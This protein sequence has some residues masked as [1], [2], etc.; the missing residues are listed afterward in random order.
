MSWRILLED[1]NTLYENKPLPLKSHS[2]QAWGKFLQG[3][4]KLE[5]TNEYYKNIPEIVIT[6]RR[7]IRC[8]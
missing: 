2:Y 8:I 1:L 7:R 4:D 3:Y 6:P 5:A